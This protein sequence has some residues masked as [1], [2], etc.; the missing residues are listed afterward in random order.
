M[1]GIERLLQI[2]AQLR[3]PEDGCPWDVEQSF[4]SIAPHTIEEA[5]EVDDAIRRGDFDSLRE[6]LGDLLLQ[7][8]FHARMAE[9]EDRFDFGEVV[10]EISDKLVR[11]HPHVF[12]DA[13]IATSQEQ[14]EA[15]E[16]QKAEERRRKGQTSVTDGIPVALPA[17][18]RARKLLGRAAREGFA[19]PNAAAAA[20]RVDDMVLEV[21]KV[22]D[23]RDP[24]LMEHHLGNLL[25]ATAAL[26]QRTEVDPEV[27]LRKATGRLADRILRV[28]G[29]LRADGHGISD[30]KVVDLMD[31][32]RRAN[33]P[34]SDD[35]TR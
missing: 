34:Q 16:Q 17:L 35:E 20:D 15:W 13:S 19:W 3:D 30:G 2:M 5:Y 26:A 32:W 28:E 24:E 25:I 33:P 11:R 1:S 21:R 10:Q 23:S 27:A 8:V 7:V 14:T 6:E 9:E 22:I 18:T 4:E 29:V 31:Y 12:A